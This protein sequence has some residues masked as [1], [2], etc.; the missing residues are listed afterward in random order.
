[1]RTSAIAGLLLPL[2]LLIAQEPLSSTRVIG[3]NRPLTAPSS[4]PAQEIASEFLNSSAAGLGLAKADLGSV[5]VAR[6]YTDAHNGVTHILYRQRYQGALVYNSAFVVNIDSQGQVLNAGGDLF[7]SPTGRLPEANSSNEALS[8]AV[9]AVNPA[10][11]SSFVPSPSMALPRRRDA[12]RFAPGTLSDDPEGRMVWYAARGVVIPVWQFFVTGEDRVTLHSVLVDANS[13]HVVAQRPLTY[14]QAP[15][16]PR[17]LVFERE[18]P[19]PNPVPGAPIT[20]VPPLADRTLQSFAGDPLASP[21]G[22]TTSSQTLGNNAIVGENLLGTRF[23]REVVPTRALGGDFSF[24]LQLG[25]GAANPLSYRDAVNT[26]LF[27]WINRAHDLF[28]ASGFTEAAGNFQESNFGRGGLGG[29]P[30]YAYSH[31][32]AQSPESAE[33]DNAYFSTLDDLDGAASMI[34]MFIAEGGGGF[35]D[36]AL[37]S[38]VIVHE[39]THGV[40]IRL[41]P[42]GYDSFQVAAMGEAWSDFYAIEFLTPNGAPPD[43]LYPTSSYFLQTW[44]KDSLRTRPYSTQLELNPLTFAD[45]GAVIPFQ[46]VHSD[47]EIWMEALWEAR[48]NLIQQLGEPEGRRRIRQLVLDGMKLAPPRSTMVDMRDAILLA[49]RVDFKGESQ[50][51]LWAA[52]AKR[53]FGALA[54]S[55][56]PD[57]THVIPSFVLPSAKGQLAFYDRPA[58]MGDLV[59][60]VVQDSNYTAAS[61]K[62]QLTSSSGDLEDM[63]LARTGSIYAGSIST[64]GNVINKQNG[65]LNLTPGDFVSAYYTDYDAPGGATQISETIPVQQPYSPTAAQAPEF[66]F[67]TERQVSPSGGWAAKVDLPFAF[68]YYGKSYRTMFVHENGLISFGATANLSQLMNGNCT[69]SSTLSA[70]AGVAPLWLNMTTAGGAQSG[71]GVFVTR[72][73]GNSVTVRWAGETVSAFGYD[74]S[75]LNFAATLFYDGRIQ[76][77]YGPGNTGLD[78]AANPN[79]CGPAPSVGISPG[80]DSYTFDTSLPYYTNLLVKYD[81]PFGNNTLPVV[82]IETPVAG[83]SA[84]D[85]LTV[86]GLAYDAGSP[87]YRV[88]VLID[89]VKRASVRP[90]VARPD[91]CAAASLPGCPAVGY[92]ANITTAAIGA[93]EHALQIRVTNTRGGLVD[94][95]EQPLMFKVESGTA[96]LPFGKIESPAEGEEVTGMLEVSGYAAANDLR[97]TLVDTLIDGITYGPTTYGYSRAAVCAALSPRPLNCNA[98]GFG[99][100]LDT[101]AAVPPLANGP[102]VIQMRVRDETGRYTLVPDTPVNFTIKNAPLQ[103]LMGSFTSIKTGDTLSGIVTIVGHAY[104]PDGQI[105]AGTLVVDSTYGYG[106]VSYGSGRPEVCASLPDVAACPRIGFTYNLDTRRLGNGPHTLSVAFFDMDGALYYLPATGQPVLSVVVNNP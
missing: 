89:G 51:P 65:T 10:A 86:R 87:I 42:R 2:S 106:S 80:H 63:L 90:T 76:F 38:G 103:S 95:P 16:V 98:I 84:N 43:G 28:Y 12:V 75:P 5:F 45:A 44:G 17:G 102:H 8:A 97:V 56:N 66:K 21:L 39:Y 104:L 105:L 26:N 79:Y 33:V 71:E 46:E 48:A 7:A 70:I 55:G 24:P 31:F 53:G 82:T 58:V 22:W 61:M 64:S 40:S 14:F 47:G 60:V 34:A 62:I 78:A 74:G 100:Y 59:R 72:S 81:P 67:A 27:Y 9:R 20:V 37:D 54:W 68:P 73:I 23:W 41:L 85:V 25:T 101:T 94:F 69:D 13:Q 32:G 19:Q 29:D 6:Q 99:L 18:S 88:D 83:G 3:V 93:G 77:H 30:V 35:T 36:G 15:S 1:M 49:D 96:R 91:A 57:T 52:F 50:E 92:V 11:A 4:R